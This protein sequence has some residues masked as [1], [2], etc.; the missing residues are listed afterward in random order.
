M[1]SLTT[2]G[3]WL[4]TAAQ[5][6]ATRACLRH[7]P[8]DA[9]MATVNHTT[10]LF[11]FSSLNIIWRPRIDGDVIVRDPLVSVAKGLYAK[12]PIMTGDAD[13]EGT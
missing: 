4:P 6:R 5:Q 12:I 1:A 13:D 11:S 3:W 8:F 10:N 2:T 9:F 7:V